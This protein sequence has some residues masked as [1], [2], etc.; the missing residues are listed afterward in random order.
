MSL[1]DHLNNADIAI[2]RQNRGWGGGTRE[3]NPHPF[4]L[5]LK[6]DIDTVY[7]SLEFS[8][9][10]APPDFQFSSDIYIEK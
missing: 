8:V 3:A 6:I 7:W 9:G 2:W 5:W 1:S 10:E 4:L